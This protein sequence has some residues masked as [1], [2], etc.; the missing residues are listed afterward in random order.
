[1]W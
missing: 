1:P